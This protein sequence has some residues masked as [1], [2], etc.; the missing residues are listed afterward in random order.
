MNIIA[1]EIAALDEV[2]EKGTALVKEAMERKADIKQG[3]LASEGL[4]RINTAVKVRIEARLS[5]LK[6]IDIEAKMVDHQKEVAQIAGSP[7]SESH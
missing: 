3:R 7:E 2:L 5:Q 6:L 1:K 4:G